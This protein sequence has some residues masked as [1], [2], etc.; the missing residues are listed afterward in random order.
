MIQLVPQ[1]NILLAY[2]PF[3]LFSSSFLASAHEG[4]LQG[5]GDLGSPPKN[6]LLRAPFDILGRSVVLSFLVILGKMAF[7]G[8]T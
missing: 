8:E 6:L 5:H 1:L 4:S 7:P 3:L 2:E